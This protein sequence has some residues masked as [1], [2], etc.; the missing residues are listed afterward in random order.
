M[1]CHADTKIPIMTECVM[2]RKCSL[3]GK[4]KIA[5]NPHPE[6]HTDTRHKV[7]KHK[8]QNVSKGAGPGGETAGRC[9]FLFPHPQSENTFIITI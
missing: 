9:H 7:R 8:Y 6:T 4:R 1:K 2:M 3:H 5:Y